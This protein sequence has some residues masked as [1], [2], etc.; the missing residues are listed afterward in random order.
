MITKDTKFAD[1]S[2]VE[3]CTVVAVAVIGAGVVIA[4]VAVAAGLLRNLLIAVWS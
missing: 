1:M 2:I 3:K 4:V